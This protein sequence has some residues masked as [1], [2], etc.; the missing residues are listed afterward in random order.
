[1]A[2]L[3]P[4]RPLYRRERLIVGYL[5]LA[6]FALLFFGRLTDGLLDLPLGAMGRSL[7]VL[8]A[9]TL[10]ALVFLSVRGR[11]YARALRLRLPHTHH[12]PF[13]IAAFFALFSGALLLSVLFGG[14]DTLGTTAVAFD[15]S[16]HGTAGETLL[17]A[18]LVAIL[19][20][21]A[22]ELC[23]RGIAATEY[24]RRGAVRA[25]LLS[26]LLF[27]LVHFD[28]HN[29][30]A[31]LFSGVLLA[32]V[33][34]ATDSLLA[35]MLL[36]ALYNLLALFTHGYLHTLYRITGSVTLFLFFFIV[37][38]LVSLL[39]LARFGTRIY[40][41]RDTLNMRDPR[42]D[43]PWNVQFHTILDALADPPL[44]LTL[45]LAVTGMIVL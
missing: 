42:R 15:A 23:F 7:F 39:L 30:L 29:L 22:E 5:M 33:L 1:M 27:A 14:L 24:E 11:G 32:L 3:I 8:A 43:V 19:P 45:V 36:H 25:I 37:I 38:L 12:I 2:H 17:S 18:L 31:Y 13:L 35:T 20:A 26:T 9:F 44:L 10:P 21:M 4:E 6:V 16:K 28:P 40:R 34:Y 41:Q